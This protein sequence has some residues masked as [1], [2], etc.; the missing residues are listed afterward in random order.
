MPRLGMKLGFV[1]ERMLADLFNQATN[2]MLPISNKAGIFF[3]LLDEDA[4]FALFGRETTF[5]ICDAGC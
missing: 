4:D 5:E 3:L 1:V 2:L